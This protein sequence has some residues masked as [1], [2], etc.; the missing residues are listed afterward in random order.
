MPQSL[1]DRLHEEF[2]QRA[3]E[4]LKGNSRLAGRTKPALLEPRK[5]DLW[6]AAS[7]GQ[8]PD[9]YEPV[10]E[11]SPSS[12]MLNAVGVGL[13]SFVDTAAFGIPGSLVAEEEFLDFEDPVAKWTGAVTGF[14]GFVAGAPMKIG[15]KVV[16]KAT[17]Q[18][19]PSMVGKQGLSTVLKGMRE[20]GKSGGLSRKSIRKATKGYEKLVHKA[21]IDETL[22]GEAFGRKVMQYADEYIALGSKPG[23]IIK[24]PQEAAAIRR[25]FT[26]EALRRPLQDFKGLALARHG[27][28]KYARWLGHAINDVMMFSFIDSVFEGV[29][30]VEDHHYDF[31]APLWGAVN[32]LAFSTLSLLNPKGKA[33]SWLRDY[34]VGLRAAFGKKSAFGKMDKDQLARSTRFMGESLAASNRQ[35]T[36]KGLTIEV[37]YGKYGKKN[38]RLNPMGD[39]WPAED[40][41]RKTLLEWERAFGDDAEKAM[42]FWLEGQRKT[43]GREMMRWANAE[44]ASHLFQVWPR[45]VMG[46]LLFNAHSFYNMFAHDQEFDVHDILPHFL[47]GAYMQRRS[48]PAKFDLDSAGINKVRENLAIL[49]FRPDQLSFVP[50]LMMPENEFRNPLNREKYKS[51]IEIAESEG[52]VSDNNEIISTRLPEGVSSIGVPQNKNIA[53]EA[54]YKMLYGK[55]AFIKPI[56]SIS[57]ESARKIVDEFKKVNPDVDLKSEVSLDKLKDLESEKMTEDF[58]KNFEGVVQSLSTE[59]DLKITTNTKG[60]MR[61]PEL[62]MESQELRKRARNGELE[63]LKDEAGVALTGDEAV[64]ALVRKIDGFNSIV[65][66]SS[67]LGQVKLNSKEQ[68]QVVTIEDAA[69]ARK[70]YER[71][72][73]EE[74]NVNTMFPNKSGHVENFSFAGSFNDYIHVLTRNHA[75]KFARGAVDIFKPEYTGKDD[76]I[77]YLKDAGILYLER[78]TSKPLIIDDVDRINIRGVEAEKAAELKRFLGRVLTLQSV[79]G[80]YEGTE[81]TM[82]VEASAVESLRR[83]LSD[84]GYNEEKIPQWLSSHMVD[85]A[86]REKIEGTDLSLGD[87]DTVFKLSALGFAKVGVEVGKKAAGFRVRLV[88]E[89]FSEDNIFAELSKG[90]VRKYNL[91]VREIVDRSN[92]LIT[93][94]AERA[95]ITDPTMMRLLEDALPKVDAENSISATAKLGE[96]LSLITDSTVRGSSRFRDQLGKFIEDGGAKGQ[97]RAIR[98]MTESGVIKLSKATR[99]WDVA[100]EAYNEEVI[101]RVS[102][103][104]DMFGV[105]P[106]YAERAYESL[107]RNAR[108]RRML[109]VGDKNFVRNITL[110]DFFDKY[111]PDGIDRSGV[112]TNEKQNVIDNLIFEDKAGRLLTPDSVNRVL[113]RIHVKNLAGTGWIRFRDQNRVVQNRRKFEIVRDLV[114]LFGSRRGQRPVDKIQWKNGKV[115]IEKEHVQ[116]NRHEAL[117]DALG[118]EYMLIDPNVSMYVLS[119]DG[120]RVDRKQVNIFGETSNLSEYHQEQIRNARRQFESEAAVAWEIDGASIRGNAGEVGFASMRLAPNTSPIAIKVGD[121]KKIKEPFDVFAEEYLAEDSRLNQASKNRIREIQRSLQLAEDRGA[122]AVNIDYEA[123]LRRIM[124]KDMLTGSDGNELFIEFMNG[125][126]DGGIDKLFARAK[127]YN[128]KKFIRFNKDFVLD[129]ADAYGAIGDKETDRVLRDRLRKNGWGISVWNDKKRANIKEEIDALV[130]DMG[131]DWNWADFIGNAHIDVSSFDSIAFASRDVMRFNHAMAGHDPRS[132]NPMKPVISS[133]G[134]N[135]PL[136][137]GKTLFIYSPNLDSFFTNNRGVDIL[138]TKTGAKALNP[139][140]RGEV[141]DASL[142]NDA[143]WTQLPDYRVNS[144]QI[145][146]IELEGIGIK[147]ERD[148]DMTSAKES[149]ADHNY[150]NNRESSRVF[151]SDIEPPLTK[152]IKNAQSIASEP[153]SIRR[154]VL[155]QFGDDALTSSIDGT[156]SMSHLNG[157]FFFAGLTKDANPMSYSDS[158]VK[159]KMYNSYIDAIINRRRSVTNQY[160]TENSHRYGGQATLIQAPILASHNRA[161]L[162]PT[163]VDA[164]GNMKSRG[165]VLLPFHESKMNLSE[166]MSQGHEIRVV[167]DG[168]V[169]KPEEVFKDLYGEKVGAEGWSYTKDVNPNL[170]D[171][172]LLINEAS[173]EFNRPNLQ[174]GILVRRNPRTRPNDMALMGLKGFLEKQYGN[175]MMINSL[176][177]VNVFEGDYDADKAD[178]F[179]AQRGSMYDHVNRVSN[180]F[181]QGIDPSKYMKPS[182]FNWSMN[183]TDEHGMVEKMSAD[184]DL[185]NSS[186]GIVQKVPRMLNYLGS[187]GNPNVFTDKSMSAFVRKNNKGEQSAPKI[188]Y[189]GKDYRIVLD[190]ENSDFFTRAALETQYI[191]DGKGSLNGEIADNILSWRD[192]FLF[193]KMEESIVPADIQDSGGAGFINEVSRSGRSKNKRVRIFR[194]LERDN[195]SGDFIEAELSFLDKAIIKEML[196]EYGNLL[197]ATGD[198]FYE[199]SGEGRKVSYEDVM[200]AS[201]RFFKFNSDLRRSLYYRLRRRRQDITNP[202]S[203]KWYDSNEFKALF[204]VKTNTREINGKNKVWYTSEN[205]RMIDNTVTNNAVEYSNGERGSPTERILHRLYDADI[206]KQTRAES[207]TGDARRYMDDWYAELIGDPTMSGKEAADRA[208]VLTNQV[209]TSKFDVDRRVALISDLKKKVMQIKRNKNQPWKTKQQSIDKINKLIKNVED[210]IRVWL[211]EN[212]KKTRSGKDLQRIE[213]VNVDAENMKRGTIYYA[214]MEQMKR[215]LP[216]IGGSDNWGLSSQGRKDLRQLK[217]F[218]QIF[219]GNQDK[220]SDIIK[221]GDKSILRDADITLLEKFPDMSTH[222]DIENQLLFQNINKHGL[223]FLWAFM[224]PNHNKYSVGVF[225]GRPISVP[226]EA[227][228]GYDPSSRYRRGINFLTKMSMGQLQMEGM[229]VDGIEADLATKALKILQV[230]EAQFDR[231]FNRRFD[232]KGLVGD[233]IAETFDV[234]GVEA[235]KMV[236]N[237]IKLP[238]FHRDLERSFVDFGSIKWNRESE[239]IRNGFGMLNDHL[240]DFYRDLME[241]AGKGEEFESYLGKMNKLQ[242]AMMSNDIINPLAYMSAR[243]SMDGEVRNIAQQ[244]LTHGLKEGKANMEKT[245]KILSNPVWAI[246]GGNSHWKGLTLEKSSKYSVER[247]GEM[248][249]L[250]RRI[251]RVK[252]DLPVDETGEETLRRLKHDVIEIKRQC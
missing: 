63:W 171:L 81:R 226:F 166:L 4:S 187:L 200:D 220:L 87:V 1:E 126:V 180:Y 23:G 90:D 61:V 178:Y 237:A 190:Y 181:V 36:K 221:H 229:V 116:F 219:Y 6:E 155:Q 205:E 42:R 135:S 28:T 198:T 59:A 102:A 120:R 26:D 18:I 139:V 104:V 33:S 130:T 82:S 218:R 88:D 16:Q 10:S 80:N 228:E 128:T 25:M 232:L 189:E 145:R 163:L 194:R 248:S 211:P 7:Q 210:E 169:Y 74:L 58:E 14:A 127:L 121:L 109:D 138:L 68:G 62:V 137:L 93:I 105:T 160:D 244:V 40:G 149:P 13:W 207:L 5:Q 95:K 153:I 231:Y 52:I 41:A 103:K 164:N 20:A 235:E 107:D 45:M 64:D 252:L 85:Y 172:H 209:L 78:G 49:G 250:S 73:I 136:L 22:Q 99:Q 141:A 167:E 118:I 35:G 241:V 32:G 161:R 3:S 91:E 46:G 143:D 251:E 66:A 159:N 215:F 204:G 124:L 119:A 148:A 147:P 206:F 184:L 94:E 60:E 146:N 79:A 17:A 44:E 239:R 21:Q 242:D 192:R 223:K 2:L 173:R 213:F 202:N 24:S 140:R 176:D 27:N 71:I 196:N 48:N 123:A 53:F 185:Y 168:K 142:I 234:G 238:N 233:N 157:M 236:Y 177:V 197:N 191:I 150:F 165:E 31:T 113:D 117:F 201:E 84:L 86:I 199:N 246:M 208:D 50:S 134:E 70:V 115:H 112:D 131:I 240:F 54:V 67:L 245:S 11:E 188:L 129:V 83:K 212:Y 162:K 216:L 43:Y 92:G 144:N 224:Q 182:G 98:W 249:A 110:Q 186:I 75:I 69:L 230:S 30:T 132:F 114:G 38:I 214:T 158:I 125:N 96:F 8:Y 15:A 175:A 156:D 72:S 225:N 222:Y 12:N 77:S 195:V 57:V 37:E 89:V 170:G 193:P 106:E 183:S 47:I 55:R 108:D 100:L 56:D 111:R 19:A 101:R 151:E 243:Q 97:Q 34:K 65:T 76:L 154:W 122:P 217:R 179:F 247:L 9:W 227:N 29:S 174:L 203:K 152:A 133:G 51:V 39:R